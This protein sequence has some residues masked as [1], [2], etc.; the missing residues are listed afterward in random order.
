MDDEDID[1]GILAIAQYVVVTPGIKQSH[2]I[3]T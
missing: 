3:Y 2:S 1:N